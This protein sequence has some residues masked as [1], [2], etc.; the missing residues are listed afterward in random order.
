MDITNVTEKTNLSMYLTKFQLMQT[1]SFT[2]IR[3]TL[4][5]SSYTMLVL[6]FSIFL[7]ENLYFKT[8]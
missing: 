2:N 4:L 6:I 7:Y 1:F 5:D 8:V 3:Y